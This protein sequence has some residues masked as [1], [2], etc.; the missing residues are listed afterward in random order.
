MM[1]SLDIRERGTP[2][3]ETEKKNKKDDARGESHDRIRCVLTR[4]A[5]MGATTSTAVAA[6]TARVFVL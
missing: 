2:C 3:I 1:I 6:K 5:W 4:P